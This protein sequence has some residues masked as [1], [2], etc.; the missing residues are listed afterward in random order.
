M[1]YSMKDK[2]NFNEPPQ[3][4]V[5]GKTLTVQNDAETI[6]ELLDIVQNNGEVE[7]A[8]SAMAHLFSAKDQKVIA[9]LKLNIQ[10]FLTLAT[11]AMDL[12]LGNDPD[13]EKRGE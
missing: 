6:L 8:R 10:D 12:A 3:I 11:V 7:G 2:L 13:E 5:K 1:I 4:E 9:G